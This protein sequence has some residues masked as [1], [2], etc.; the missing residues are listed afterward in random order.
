MSG[1]VGAGETGLVVRGGSGGTAVGLDALDE[2]A[3]ALF[4]VAQ[5]VT[6]MMRL[7]AALAVDPDLAA[8]ALLSP[9]TGGP[10]TAALLAAVGPLG[11]AGEV[12]ALLAL[13]AS[14]RTA[15][16]AYRGAEAAAG[17]AVEQAQDSMLFVAGQLA[18]QLVVANLVL[19]SLG[20]DVGARLDHFLFE[21]PAVADLAGGAEGLVLGLATNPLTAPFVRTRPRPHDRRG[22]RPR[23]GRDHDY[24]DAVQILADSA[25][26]WGLLDDAGRAEVVAEPVPRPGA[27]APTT[28]RDLA[29]AQRNVDDGVDYPGHVRIIEVPQPGGSVWVVEISGTQAWNPRAGGTPFDVT[30]DV[31]LMA[32]DATVLADGVQQALATAQA[33]SVI[34]DAAQTQPAPVMLVGHSLGGIT[35]AGLASSP[36]FTERHRVTHVVTMGA[37]VGRM[38]VPAETQVLSLEHTR[39]PVPRLDG[40][41]NPD[42]ATWVTVTRDGRGDRVDGASHTHDVRGYVDT[43][44]LVDDSSDPSVVTWRSTSAPFFDADAHGEPVIRDFAIRRVRP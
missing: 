21:H 30:T 28:L 1:P 16:T 39:D 43:A 34:G 42:R 44:G 32:Q 12:A 33:Q 24:E 7:V 20:V 8:G 37:P 9:T 11:L 4:E 18:P 31:H 13:S 2:A 5:E 27:S 38:P 41:P 3:G 22:P 29:A 15:S 25:A 19:D 14:V 10:A 35:A 17:A 40:Q 23:D 26:V 6:A 36:L